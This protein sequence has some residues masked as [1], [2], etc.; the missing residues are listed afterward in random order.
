MKHGVL[1]ENAL[2][3]QLG[4]LRTKVEGAKDRGQMSLVLNVSEGL[5]LVGL[6]DSLVELLQTKRLADE[7]LRELADSI[8][9]PAGGEQA[10]RCASAS[11]GGPTVTTPAPAAGEETVALDPFGGVAGR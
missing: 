3:E 10:G 9:T 4:K 11:T 7:E 6:S 5:F 8:S 2:R 1:L